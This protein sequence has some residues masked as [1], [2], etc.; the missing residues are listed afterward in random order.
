[1]D[2]KNFSKRLN[3]I[4]RFLDPQDVAIYLMDKIFRL[5]SAENFTDW[6]QEEIDG[7][8]NR[9]FTGVAERVKNKS[10]QI[11]ASAVPQAEAE[12][13]RL[14]TLWIG[15]DRFAS[16]I[17]R[18][19]LTSIQVLLLGRQRLLDLAHRFDAVLDSLK[20]QNDAAYPLSPSDAAVIGAA[21]DH[22]VETWESLVQGDMLNWLASDVEEKHS[23]PLSD[24]EYAAKESALT[25]AARALVDAHVVESGA[26]TVI[27]AEYEELDLTPLVDREWIDRDILAQAEFV[28][29]A[30]ERGFELRSDPSHRLAP[31]RIVARKEQHFVPVGDSTLDAM[32]DQARAAIA[33]FA[34][35]AREID[36][37]T[38]INIHD[39]RAWGERRV[40]GDLKIL[41]GIRVSS[42]NAWV[43][44]QGGEG[45]AM[46]AG[47][48][49]GKLETIDRSNIWACANE[50]QARELCQRRTKQLQRIAKLATPNRFETEACD[51][52][53]DVLSPWSARKELLAQVERVRE[54]TAEL[55]EK[56][57]AAK[58]VCATISRQDFANHPMLP[59]K[60]KTCCVP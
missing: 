50:E 30:E 2:V 12:L 40:K 36:G 20:S 48:K 5:R 34:G 8:I 49:V 21:A 23:A 33:S 47:V 1:M 31:L 3:G 4:E 43:D 26:A 51:G 32:R 55:L 7:L 9:M 15:S 45:K 54:I 18:E 57:W 11:Q 17:I 46:L 16:T 59:P 41:E 44:T 22:R 52:L 28:A 60:T 38:Y 27:G 13:R 29:A 53:G 25:E 10:L 24:H 6:R 14:I 39:Y 56:L 58:F 19:G 37:R 35:Q 42:W